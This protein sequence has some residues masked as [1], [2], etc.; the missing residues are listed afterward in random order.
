MISKINLKREGNS[1]TIVELRHRTF[2]SQQPSADVLQSQCYDKFCRT[3]K[4]LATCAKSLYFF[5]SLSQ[6][7]KKTEA[8]VQMCTVRKVF[9]KISRNSQKNNCAR[10]SFL[11]KFTGLRP[12]TYNFIKKETLA[13]VFSCEFAKFLRTPFFNRT[14]PVVASE[15]RDST[16]DVL[17]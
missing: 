9:L 3:H 6:F 17:L 1:L 13:Q 11:I 12:T 10:V 4:K 15:K 8:V 16:R 7:F 14:H 2:S 5:Y